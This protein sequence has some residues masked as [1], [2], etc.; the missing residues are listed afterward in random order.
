M[1]SVKELFSL[2]GRVA[3]VTGASRGLGREVAEA[4]GEAGAK[5]VLGARR[6][7]WLQPTLHELRERGF[8]VV[9]QPCDISDPLQAEAIVRTALESFGRLDILVNNAGISW[10]AP[11]EE[12]PLDRW[13]QVIEIN[14]TGTHLMTRAALPAMKERRYGKIINVASVTG[15]VGSPEDVL[16]AA[17]YTASKGAVVALTRDV[18]VKYARY[19]ICVNAIAPGYFPTRMTEGVLAHATERI[20]QLTPMGRLGEEGDLKGIIVFLASAASDYVT[21]QIIAIDGG[22]TAM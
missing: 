13:R 7:Q 10:G 19:G 12:M 16:Q 18:A 3:I 8:D 22:M 15:L 21:G 20:K 4:L 11:Y 14:L 9:A 5:V 1:R 2:D 17:G 6:E